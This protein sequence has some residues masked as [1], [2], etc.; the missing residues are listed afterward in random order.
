MNLTKLATLMAAV[1]S[2]SSILVGCGGGGGGTPPAP[3]P[4]APATVSVA[5]KVVDGPISNATVCF[6]TNDNGACDSGE[7]SARTDANGAVT[8]TVLES[9]AGKHALIAI[10]GT[11]AVDQDHGPVTQSYTLTTTAD[12][13]ALLSPLTTL[14]RANVDASGM[15]TADAEKVLQDQLGLDSS[16]FTDFTS[17]NDP[18]AATLAQLARVIALIKAQ[19]FDAW[20]ASVGANDSAGNPM[21]RADIDR[22]I[23][24]GL[25]QQAQDVIAVLATDAVRNAASAADRD[26]AIRV[27]ATALVAGQADFD[28]AKAIPA[29]KQAK[30]GDP[31]V[32][33]STATAGASLRWFTY[34]DAGNWYFRV[35]ESSA[36]QSVPDANGM[37]HFTEKRK[38]AVNGTVETWGSTPSFSRNDLYWTGTEWFACPTG[39][40]HPGTPF[41]SKGES[42][43]NYCGAWKSINRRTARDIAGAKIADIVR[44]IRAYPLRDT[45]GKLAAWGPNPDDPLLADLTFP[46]GSKLWYYSGTDLLNP[47]AYRP[48]D[49]LMVFNSDVANGVASECNKVTST[50]FA[51]FQV[52][53]TTLEEMVAAT[54]G[55]PCVYTP[56]ADTGPRNEWWSNSTVSIG[57]V[58]GPASTNPYYQSNRSLRIG[59]GSGQ[60]VN[61]YT[62]AI[63]TQGG[64]IRHCDAIGTG[65]YSIETLGDA[66][67]MRF[68]N[69][70]AEAAP[71]TYSRLFVERGGSVYYGYKT[72]L[73][74]SNQIRP[75]L[76]ATDALFAP[77]GITR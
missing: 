1:G 55:K 42:T 44:E 25:L 17:G 14:V 70:P 21:T 65:T 75:N 63:R 2:L 36:Q 39:F 49:L 58:A 61:F 37:R 30:Q 26:A 71:L 43:S 53:P 6:D 67:V 7:P 9:D 3:P 47:A 20:K 48:T 51:N 18:Q 12:K 46:A 35:F 68:A 45:E 56:N 27:A 64:S 59:F 54:A 10:V 41:D 29:I 16:L 13:P 34:S 22:A 69:V 60:S 28:P 33:A 74:V 19:T 4:P 5:T 24:L 31:D 11:D 57:I 76:E 23:E 77:L 52:K 8:L 72:K 66:R 40:E 50:N 32:P 73:R 38:R 15:S 62:C